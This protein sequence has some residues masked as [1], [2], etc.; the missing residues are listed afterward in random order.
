MAPA[1]V[2]VTSV[3]IVG[4]S[5]AAR[6]TMRG[7]AEAAGLDVAGDGPLWSD[8]LASGAAVLVAVEPDAFPAGD[9]ERDLPPIVV[10]S[11]EAAAVAR[12]AA[13]GASAWGVLP[14]AAT[15]REL[16]AAV[17]AVSRGLAV[18]PPSML[19]SLVRSRG[20]SGE[21]E[22]EGPREHLTRRERH[23]LELVAEGRSNRAIGEALGISEHTV[24][25]HLASIYGK[26]GASTRTEAVRRGLRRGLIT[27]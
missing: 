13:A 14:A 17:D 10:V 4:R 26:L 5:A 22:A 9:G 11:D 19:A 20:E 21:D 1:V 8:A 2:S 23:V 6:S 25:F 18:A 24:K 27:I 12:A 15:P 3:F 7:R 16:A